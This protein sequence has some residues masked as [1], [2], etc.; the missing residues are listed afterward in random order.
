MDS[1]LLNI[2]TFFW[3]EFCTLSD[4]IHELLFWFLMFQIFI[5]SDTCTLKGVWVDD[6]TALYW[7]FPSWS[8][9]QPWDDMSATDLSTAMGGLLMLV[10][11]LTG[12]FHWFVPT[13]LVMAKL[14]VQI[15]S[16]LG[17]F[18][19]IFLLRGVEDPPVGRGKGKLPR[20]PPMGEPRP[21]L[22]LDPYL[23]SCFML[24]FGPLTLVTSEDIWVLTVDRGGSL[25]E[26]EEMPL[27]PVTDDVL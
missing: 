23:T 14:G 20:V 12:E 17:I 6:M 21:S 19:L 10:L 18:E 25:S 24:K 11:S 8:W 4:L 26:R 9:R 2:E 15:R 5:S 16:L 1:V 3:F 22:S 13:L 7:A 27:P